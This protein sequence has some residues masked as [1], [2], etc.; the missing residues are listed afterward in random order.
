MTELFFTIKMVCSAVVIGLIIL[1]CL[2]LLVKHLISS[3]KEERI[4]KYLTSIGYRR[5]IISTA[6]FGYNHTYGYRRYKEDGWSDVI[7]DYELSGMS[8]KQVKNKYH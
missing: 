5:E 4:K 6:S 7:R 2:I 8:L 3:F 1:F